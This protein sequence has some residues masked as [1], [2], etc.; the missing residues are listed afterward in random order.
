MDSFTPIQPIL[1][2]DA[3]AVRL[4]QMLR[5]RGLMVTAIRPPTVPAGSARLRVTLTAAHS[6]A[7]VQLLLKDWPIVFS[8][9]DRSQ[10]MRDRLI[11]L[12]GWGSAF[13]RWNPWQRRC[14]AWTSTCV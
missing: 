4:S 9:W 12:P 8:N 2:G 14:R 5:E 3:G 10:A 11:L 6:E 7:Q 13:R 1:I